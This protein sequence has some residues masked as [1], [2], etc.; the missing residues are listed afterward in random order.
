MQSSLYRDIY[1]P[2][3][4]I[5]QSELMQDPV[6][7]AAFEEGMEDY[8]RGFSY[9][10][11]TKVIG[12][13]EELAWKRGWNNLMIGDVESISAFDGKHVRGNHYE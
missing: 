12:S 3:A 2:L 4:V 13:R 9:Q 10:R 6:C 5:P 1:D 7:K 11:C 8:T